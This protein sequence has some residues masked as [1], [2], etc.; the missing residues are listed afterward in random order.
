MRVMHGPSEV[1]GQN[2]Y[3]VLGLREIG[4][5]AESVVFSPHPF[6]Y[7]YDRS[8]GVD[9]ANRAALPVNVA[10][11]GLSFL[12]ACAS[13][14]VFHFHYGHSICEGYD[15]PFYDL[16]KKRYFFE[17]HGSDIRDTRF[18][19]GFSGDRFG[20]DNIQSDKSKKRI[21][22]LCAK[23]H[24]IVLHDDELIA[25]LPESHAPVYVIPLRLDISQFAPSFPDD[26]NNDV[27]KVVHAPSKRAGKGSSFVIDAIEQLQRGGLNVELV[28]VE[29]KNQQE[30]L[31]LYAQADIIVDQLLAGTYGVFAIESMA[32]GKPVITYIADE[33]KAAFPEELPI[34]S[35]TPESISH[36]IAGLASSGSL[37][38]DL[39]IASRE[40]AETYHDYRNIAYMLRDLYEGVLSPLVGRRAFSYVKEIAT[41]RCGTDRV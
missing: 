13:Y 28:L 32:L 1:A 4:V 2:W 7:P 24:G 21:A 8:L 40:Y 26:N 30:A 29:G 39:G 19:I 25:H 15:L 41:S 12:R 37:R 5:D 31:S 11:L 36:V 23:A 34:V 33:M 9:K 10:R 3:S 16:L 27:V 18:S 14:D 35:A 22:R 17:F 20:F 6:G 38:R